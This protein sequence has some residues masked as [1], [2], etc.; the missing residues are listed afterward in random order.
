VD[1]VRVAG[2]LLSLLYCGPDLARA[3]ESPD[4][5][6]V[7]NGLSIEGRVGPYF[8]PTGIGPDPPSFDYVRMAARLGWMLNDA[9]RW[10]GA[11][12]GAFEAVFE[13]SGGPTFD[14]FGDWLVGPS[15]AIRYNFVQPGWKIVPYLQGGVGI[16]FSDAYQDKSQDAI[17]TNPEFTIQAAIGAR[18]LL[19]PHWSID[20]EAGYEHISNADIAERNAGVNALGASVGFSYFFDLR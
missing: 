18:W 12:R 13:V 8:S 10:S 3:A 7:R 11:L 14:S 6:F 2:L 20:V 15:A 9:S 4:G 16:T 17:G 5:P 1:R 19:D